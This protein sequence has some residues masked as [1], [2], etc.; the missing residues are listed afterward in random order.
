MQTLE[1]VWE[2]YH[3]LALVGFELTTEELF[4]ARNAFYSG[5]IASLNLHFT[6]E[7]T[8][9]T[10]AEYIVQQESL[11]REIQNYMDNDKQGMKLDS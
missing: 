2:E 4:M 5:A 1:E 7:A 3:E 11:V 6:I 9:K 8:S 10:Q